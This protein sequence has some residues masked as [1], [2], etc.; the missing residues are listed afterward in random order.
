MVS[1]LIFRNRRSGRTARRPCARQT[2]YT[3]K[4]SA[5]GDQVFRLKSAQLASNERCFE[6]SQ[7]RFDRARF[8]QARLLPGGQ[9]GFVIAAKAAGDGSKDKIGMGQVVGFA[10]EN[11][12]RALL[13]GRL[14]GVGKGTSNTSPGSIGVID[15]I[16]I[17]VPYPR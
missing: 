15:G 12:G 9:G 7:K 1:T 16:F 6:R 3:G 13:D 17:V 10:A 8:G 2:Q 14:V 11:D 4:E 5:N